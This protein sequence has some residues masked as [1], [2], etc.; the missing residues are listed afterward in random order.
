MMFNCHIN[1][2][3]YSSI[4]S[5]KYL[6]KYVYKGHDKQV[7]HVDQDQKTDVINEIKRYQDARYVSPPE[8]MW[9]IFSFALSQVHPPVLALQLHL[10]NKQMVRFRD[11]DL[12]SDIVERERNGRTMLIAF[13][14]R[15]RGFEDSRQYLYKEIPQHFIWN[16]T[17]RHWIPRIQNPQR[18]R[19]VLANPAEG[20][21]FYLRIL[22]SNVK[23]STSFEDLRTV[24]GEEYATFRK[25]A[26]ERGL[27]DNDD[28]LSLCLTEASVFQFPVALRRLFATIMIFCEPGDIN[29]L[30]NDHYEALSED[31]RLH[32]QSAE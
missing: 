14:E 26:L 16:S 4:K 29:K 9:R 7:I 12:M 30:W 5:V 8:S 17:T 2:E 25:A 13:F 22:L 15:N 23:G 19:I 1:V 11:D 6:F 27:I 21:R 3:V 28:S 20:E 32:C 10:P 18:G 31:H 24:N